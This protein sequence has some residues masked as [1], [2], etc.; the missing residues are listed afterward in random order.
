MITELPVLSVDRVSKRFGGV[1]A[2]NHL[3]FNVYPGEV[4]GL[5]GPN[6][7]GKTTLLNI[8]AG[9]YKPDAGEIEFRGKIITGLPPYKICHL[10]IARTYQIPQPFSNLTAMQNVLLAATYSRR[11]SREDAQAQAAKVM[12][13]VHLTDKKDILAKDLLVVTLKRLEL[14][15]ALA[16]TPTLLL[17][18]EVAAGLNEVE[19]PQVLNI[20]K[21]VRKMGITVILI[22]HIMKVMV[23]AVDR[24]I[25]L[26]KGE[27]I[28][29][30][31]P[32]EIME[33]RHV[34]KAYLG[35]AN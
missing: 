19:V 10:G 24:I 13:Y 30:G 26:D 17:M 21:D 7:A 2:I 31:V 32:E 29:E 25:V 1:F 33:N 16:T 14:A 9:V 34:I 3:S 18:D 11:R 5:M 35:E 4:V 27:K 6:G 8:I 28:A 23:E 20:L 12:D 22:E 15:R